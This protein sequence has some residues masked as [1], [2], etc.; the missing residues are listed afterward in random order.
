MTTERDELRRR[1]DGATA[2]LDPPLAAVDLA[3]FDAN[4]AALAA[5]AAGRPLRVASKSVRCR[6]L[7][8]RVL[9]TPGWRGVLA[10]TL[11]EANWLAATG[12]AD[13]VLVGYPTVDRA[14]LAALAV[15]A[16]LAAAVT[17]MV[18]DEA[19]LDLV[20]AVVPPA[21]RPALRVC[22]DLDAS[23]RPLAGR[24]HGGVRRSPVHSP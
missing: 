21:A 8:R 11:A 23:W 14:A 3:A 19:Q 6:L 2:G 7:L 5:R 13:D 9:A 22:L 4:G 12:V 17:L 10:Y 20:D 15:D 18:D 24:A 1:L 16:D